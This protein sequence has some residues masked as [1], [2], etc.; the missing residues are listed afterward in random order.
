MVISDRK[1]L[2]IT[3]DVYKTSI[4]FETDGDKKKTPKTKIIKRNTRN[5]NA[6]VSIRRKFIFNYLLL[7]S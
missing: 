7:F 3:R 6:G 2:T 4:T 5:S 1:A